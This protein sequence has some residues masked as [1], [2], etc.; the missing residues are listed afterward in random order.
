MFQS[1]LEVLNSILQRVALVR[2]NQSTRV[3]E[4]VELQ[5]LWPSLYNLVR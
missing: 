3:E 2:T 5:T 4:V 1:S